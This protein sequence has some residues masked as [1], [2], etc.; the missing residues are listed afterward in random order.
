MTKYLLAVVAVMGMSTV[1]C[2]GNKCDDAADRITAKIE[3]CGGKA[4]AATDGEGDTAE[5][6]DEAATAAEKAATDF[7]AQDCEA[8]KAIFPAE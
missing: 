2:G 6:T 5:C 1:A 4:P 3:E 7:E 8:I